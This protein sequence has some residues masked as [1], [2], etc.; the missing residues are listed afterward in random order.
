MGR[1]AQ[2][3]SIGQ[4]IFVQST[5][6]YIKV[7][8]RGGRGESVLIFE[9]AYRVLAKNAKHIVFWVPAISRRSFELSYCEIASRLCILRTTGDNVDFD[10]LT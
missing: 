1:E 9:F 8:R 5:H 6:L 3:Q 2:L 4:T 7:C 10:Q